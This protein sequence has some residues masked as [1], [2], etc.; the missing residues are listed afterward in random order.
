MDRL[1][2]EAEA[3]PGYR[4]AI[5]LDQQTI[6]TPGGEHLSFH[7]PVLD[8]SVALAIFAAASVTY[9]RRESERR[10][11]GRLGAVAR[12]VVAGVRRQAG[13]A[14]LSDAAVGG[15]EFQVVV[16]AD[17]TK[18]VQSLGAFPLPIEVVPFGLKAT[19]NMIEM[20]ASDAGC[21]GEIRLR[22][23][24]DGTAFLTDSGNYLIDCAFGHIKDPESLDEALKFV[25]GVVENGLF[26]GVADL[27]IIGGG[28][29]GISAGVYAARKRLKTA[30]KP[31]F[32]MSMLIIYILIAL[33]KSYVMLLLIW[34]IMLFSI[35]LQLQRLKEI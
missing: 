12:D 29:A 34:L 28:P 24:T 5:D 32:K 3:A 20:L 33:E 21:K 25:P 23:K 10:L 19:L 4:L 26:L 16:I 6:S 2:K 22:L 18:L 17:E 13:P 15:E 35:A 14:H 8:L 31:L 11:D 7:N 9:L 30:L 1:F 27:V